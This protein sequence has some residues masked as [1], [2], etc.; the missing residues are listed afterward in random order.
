MTA[1]LPDEASRVL[2]FWFADCIPGTDG[3][4]LEERSA[5]WFRPSRALD[6]EIEARF[7]AILA[8]ATRGECDF[9]CDGA[10]G[11]LAL[12][13][14]LDQFTRNVHRASA[15]AF[16]NDDAALAHCR[17]GIDEGVDRDLSYI[18][19]ACFYLPL[20]HAEDLFVQELSVERF[21]K[22]A[23]EVPP[24]VRAYYERSVEFAQEHRDIVRR[25]GRFPHRNEILGRVSTPEEID[26]LN[27]GAPRF[28]Q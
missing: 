1:G 10:R 2:R 9:W 21:E 22:L 23:D 26:Y 3:S 8:R 25:F 28:G 7:G 13:V 18:E 16:A 4:L 12:V 19:R 14:V 24:P 5:V 6:R 11:M 17:R 20:Q 15:Q 27:T